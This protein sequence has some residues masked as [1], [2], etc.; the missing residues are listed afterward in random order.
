MTDVTGFGLLGHL[1]EMVRAPGTAKGQDASVDDASTG[2]ASSS[3]SKT[4]PRMR[5]VLKASQVPLMSSAAQLAQSKVLPGAVSRNWASYGNR[6]VVKEGVEKWQQDL[7]CDPQTSGGLLIA[8]APEYVDEV[9]KAASES[10]QQQ[11][12]R[13]RATKDVFAGALALEARVIGTIVEAVEGEDAGTVEIV[14]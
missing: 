14:S 1:L 2:A 13:R 4:A 6:V 3:K 7:F 12:D 9:L 11:T 8:V 10:H 5:A